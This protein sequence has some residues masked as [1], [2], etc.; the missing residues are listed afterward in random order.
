MEYVKLLVRL[1]DTTGE[2]QYL[3]T[4]RKQLDSYTQNI[5]TTRCYPE[6]Y[7]LQ[8]KLYR[9]PLYQSVCQTGW[10]VTYEEAKM[11]VESRP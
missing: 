2:Q 10:V 6:V 7:D 8:G 1:Y 4:A 3:E 5:L 9:R 11:M